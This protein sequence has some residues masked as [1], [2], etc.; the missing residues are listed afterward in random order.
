M[1]KAVLTKS[2][3]N[4]TKMKIL[5]S[6]VALSLVNISSHQALA[7]AHLV[8]TI[9][10]KGATIHAAPKEVMLH[11]SED[12]ETSM[13]KMTVKNTK[14]GKVVSEGKPKI[15]GS[16]ANSLEV[17]LNPLKSEKASYTVNWKAVSKD[18]H[19]MQGTFEFTFDP[20][21]KE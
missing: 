14:N 5:F 8:G 20:G 19:T 12:L 10:E 21:A 17:T 11:F 7:H 4:G 1:S 2:Q 13:C 3:R 16:D 18:T 9:P 15:S 6:V